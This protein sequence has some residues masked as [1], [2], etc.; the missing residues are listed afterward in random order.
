MMN[1]QQYANST[2]SVSTHVLR[3]WVILFLIFGATSSV[4]AQRQITKAVQAAHTQAKPQRVAA[5]RLATELHP[6]EN[7]F[8]ERNTAVQLTTDEAAL[9][10]MERENP[11]FLAFEIPVAADSTMVLE[12]IPNDVFGDKYKVTNARDEEVAVKRGVFYKGIIKGDNNSVVSLALSNGELSGIVSNDR[13][14]YVLGKIKT[15]SNHIFYNDHELLEHSTFRCGVEE[16]VTRT[17][18]SGHLTTSPENVACRAVQIYIE[19]DNALYQAQGSNVT[20]VTNFVNALFGQVAVLYNNEG[21]LIQMSQL[22]IWDTADPYV[23]ATNTEQALT[24]F[25]TRIGSDFTGDLAHLLSARILGGGIAYL[26]VLCKKAEGHST[27]VSG[28]ITTTVVNVPTYS[29]NVEVVT[30]ELG[31]NFGS[32]HTQSCT[33]AGGPIDNCVAVEDGSCAAGPTPTNGGTIMSYCHLVPSIGINFN[34]GFGP[35]PGNLIRSQ[36]AACI[37]SPMSLGTPSVTNAKCFGSADGQIIVLATGGTGNVTYGISPNTGSQ[38][39]A[40]TFTGLKAQTYSLFAKDPNG[41]VASTIVTVSQPATALS[42]GV[43]STS[44]PSSANATDGSITVAATGGTSPYTFTRSGSATTNQT[45]LFTGLSFGTY[46][47]TVTDNVGC[48]AT[49]IASINDT[50]TLTTTNIAFCRSGSVNLNSLITTNGTTVSWS[51]KPPATAIAA[52]GRH[53]LALL[54]NGTVIGWGD[55][56]Y[57]QTTIPNTVVG[58]KAIAAKGLYSLALLN[59]G[60]VIGWGDNSD[61]QTTIPNTLTSATAIAAGSLHSLALL[62]NG[63]VVGWGLNNYGQTTIPNTLTN[64]TAIT[65]GSL[66]N[67]TLLSNGSV[68][69]WGDNLEGQTTIPNTVVGTKAIAAGNYHNLALL[70]NGTVTAWGRNNF[71]QTTVPNTV[72]SAIAIAAGGA[73]AGGG[74]SLALLSNGSVVGWGSNSDGQTVVPNTVVNA[75][76]IAAGSLHSLALLSNGS[77]VGWGLNN[78]GQTASYDPLPLSNTTVSPTTTKTYYVIVS[79]ASGAIKTDS[80]TVYVSTTLPTIL[81]PI[82]ANAKCFGSSDGEVIVL[83]TGGSGN[84]SYS[85]FPIAGSQSPAGVFTGLPAN[86]Y[87]FTATDIN[88]CTAKTVITIGQPTAISFNTPSVIHNSSINGFGGRVWVNAKGGTPPYTYA[89]S[90]SSTTNQTGLF[91]G[92]SAGTYTFTATDNT[93]CTKTTTVQVYDPPTLTTTNTT[94]CGSVSLDLNTLITTNGSTVTWSEKPQAIAI[95]AGGYHSL[96]L[97]STG[98]VIGWGNNGAG[99]ATPPNTVVGAKAIAAGFGHSIGLLSNGSVVAW[100]RNFSGQTTVPNTVV[101]A[102][103]IAAGAD[104]NLALLSNGSVVS[105]GDNTSGQTNVPNTLANTTAITGG[106][107]HSLALLNNGSVIGWGD[108]TIGQTSVP[109]TVVG[110]TAIAAGSY[111]NIALLGNGSVIGWGGANTP[112]PNTVVGAKAIAA[113]GNHSLALLGNGSV[114]GWGDNTAVPNTVVGATAISAGGEHS[115]ALLSN[116]SVIGWGDNTYGQSTSYN[117]LPLSNTT[118][119]PTA[120]KTYYVV[121]TNAN[122]DKTTGSVTVTVNP[123]PTPPATTTNNALSF[124]GTNDCVQITKCSGSLFAGGDALTI[125]YWFKG[126]SNQSAVRMQD[127]NGYIVAGWNGQHVLSNDGGTPSGINIGAGYNDGNWHHIA[128]TWQRNGFFTSYLDGNQVAQRAASNTPLPAFNSGVYLGAYLGISE[129]MN[130]TLDEVRVWTTARTQAQIQANMSVCTLLDQSNL[131]MYYRFDHGTANTTNTTINTLLN[132]VNSDELTGALNGFSLSSTASNW[133]TGK[134]CNTALPVELLN[135]SGKNTEGGNWLTWTTA[136]ETNTLNF[137]VERSPDGQ[138]FE[139]IGTVKAKGSH[140]TYDFTDNYRLPTIAFYRLKI[141]DLDGQFDYSKTISIQSKGKSKVKIYPSVTSGLLTIENAL[142]FHI[143]NSIGQ[144][145]LSEKQ[146][147][148]SGNFQSFSNLTHTPNLSHLPNGIYII[149]GVDTEGVLFSQKIVKQ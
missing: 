15:S 47:V 89:R 52:A 53:S 23:S 149:R 116:G 21:I 101:G 25:T 60:S 1:K 63:S 126:S 10:Q 48:T 14:N 125:E 42:I 31:H 13:G 58:A 130:G 74:H 99:Q 72:A 114:I 24:L 9:K 35:L 38:S 108:N 28:S 22:K 105:W 26:D 65:A 44:N 41:C 37:G 62:G 145:V 17:I 8:T 143:I 4:L 50:I 67:L 5:L 43:V 79:N 133:T 61:G 75:K 97:L 56:S 88:G 11:A 94:I 84:I 127:N 18:E 85:V 100:G 73:L 129:F 80:V 51:E 69:G 66:H 39:P 123:V 91:T 135:F 102:M 98:T 12:L 54:S 138:S 110:A 112:V 33:W 78:Y 121:V 32:P 107:L 46:F 68:I 29:W 137:E 2:P 71:G 103:V 70:N 87:T 120:T 40:G 148:G 92:L 124:D 142:S 117:A 36:T 20:N 82:V 64:P 136:E 76:A 19:A 27:G 113:S 55:N 30:H 144:V 90:G 139:K 134:T 45:G 128:M 141:N 109:N 3:S 140:S 16:A 111:H 95:A 6:L 122:G 131:L 57:G 115:L 132:T 59:N 106:D 119:S 93:G 49:T 104:H 146:T 96:A 118:V 86:T 77:V 7:T 81:P 34:N 147:Q 83:A